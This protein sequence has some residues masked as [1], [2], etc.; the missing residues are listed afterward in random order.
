M[1]YVSGSVEEGLINAAAA[2]MA[3]FYGL[4]FYATAGQS[5]A[6]CIDAQAGWEGAITNLLVGMAGGNFI[7]DGVGLLEFCMTASYEK[8]VIDNEIIG[9][10][11]RV[12][13]GIEV[14]AET[15]A[16]EITQRVGPGGNY[17]SEDHTCEHMRKEHFLPSVADRNDRETWGSLG[18]KDACQRAH[19]I[20]LEILGTHQPKPLDPKKADIIRKEFQEMVQ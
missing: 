20:A 16:L 7:H 11:M 4:P 14:N 17:L 15:L 9:E 13:Q 12:L 18:N 5:D 2:Q 19:E 3:Q 6:K 10:V 8:Y 1:G